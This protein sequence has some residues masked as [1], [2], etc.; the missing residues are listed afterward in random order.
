MHHHRAAISERLAK[1]IERGLGIAH[2]DYIAAVRLAERCSAQ[3]A[4]VFALTDV[5]LAPCVRGEAPEAG[6]TP[7]IRPSGAVD[8]DAYADRDVADGG[9]PQRVAGR[10]STDRPAPWRCPPARVSQWIWDSSE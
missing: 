9:R 2:A 7:A 6:T 1:I 10:D 8:A 3:L 4:G 5:L